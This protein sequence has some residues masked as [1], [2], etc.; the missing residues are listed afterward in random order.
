MQKRPLQP[1]QVAGERSK[2]RVP[3]Y[4]AVRASHRYATLI[5]GTFKP[6]RGGFPGTEPPMTSPVTLSGR[7]DK[8]YEHKEI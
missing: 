4:I 5:K 1:D 7:D 8:W 6:V 2:S 3:Q